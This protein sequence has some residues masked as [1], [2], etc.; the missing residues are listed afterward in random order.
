MT[1]PVSTD[2]FSFLPELSWHLY[3]K[4]EPETLGAL[5]IPAA[6]P[7]LWCIAN[8]H[9]LREGFGYPAAALAR[10]R[11]SCPIALPEDAELTEVFHLPD[12][13]LRAMTEPGKVSRPLLLQKRR[14]RVLVLTD[15]W[16]DATFQ[17]EFAADS[18]DSTTFLLGTAGPR[19]TRLAAITRRRLLR[20]FGYRWPEELAPDREC[21]D[22]RGAIVV[23]PSQIGNL[24]RGLADP[25]SE[26]S[27]ALTKYLKGLVASRSRLFLIQT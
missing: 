5:R 11:A 13:L 6:L 24:E 8:Y 10:I 4:D 27:L 21:G 18:E 15:A 23:E 22:W 16:L 12:M 2:E 7:T 9:E 3:K 20:L 19:C 26:D 25:S 17:H 1:I 14:D